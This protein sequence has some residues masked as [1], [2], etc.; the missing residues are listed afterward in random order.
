MTKEQE[1]QDFKQIVWQPFAIYGAC[2]SRTAQRSIPSECMTVDE[3][4]VPFRGR[5]PF[6]QYMPKIFWIC[7]AK[8]AYAFDVIIYTGKKI[9]MPV[10]KGLAQNVVLELVVQ[11]EQSGRNITCDNYFISIPLAQQLLI[12]KTYCSRHHEEKREK[13]TTGDAGS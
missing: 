13:N 6:L 1:M 12:K 5:C 2:S 8:N 7:N 9:A 3:Q 4:L 10:E 11:I